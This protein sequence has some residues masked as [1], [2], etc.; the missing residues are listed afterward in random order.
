MSVFGKTISFLVNVSPLL[1]GV[2]TTLLAY[3]LLRVDQ[4]GKRMVERELFGIIS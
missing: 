1:R 4:I 3:G 2:R